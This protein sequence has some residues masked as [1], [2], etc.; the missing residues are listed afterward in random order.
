MVNWSLLLAR[1]ISMLMS[2]LSA[3]NLR[4]RVYT[5]QDRV[6]RLHLALTDIERM[7]PD[8]QIKT[9]CKRAREQ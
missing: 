4:D 1:F 5:L 7:T 2:W 3:S 8:P 9:Q 6:D